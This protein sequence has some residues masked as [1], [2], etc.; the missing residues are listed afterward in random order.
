MYA[1]MCVCMLLFVCVCESVRVRCV[2]VSVRL[3]VCVCV[4]VYVQ[5]DEWRSLRVGQN[6]P[7]LQ[8]VLLNLSQHRLLFA[9]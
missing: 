6:I 1:C 2:G 7:S 3:S 8:Q 5:K 9:F 4:G